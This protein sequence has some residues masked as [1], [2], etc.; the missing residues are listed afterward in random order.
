MSLGKSS[1]GSAT[2]K[3]VRAGRG[4]SVQPRVA[5][6]R[7]RV[8]A[9]TKADAKARP[10]TKAHLKK[11]VQTKVDAMRQESEWEDMSESLEM[12]PGIEE[13]LEKPAANY[14][15]DAEA[16]RRIEMLR[17]ERLLQQSLSDVFDW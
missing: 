14:G 12:I 7:T 9:K 4:K 2:G 5:A 11:K 13:I 1:R 10:G 6:G 3:P 17:E 15:A 16:R 8:K